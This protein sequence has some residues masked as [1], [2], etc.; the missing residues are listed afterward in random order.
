MLRNLGLSY[1]VLGQG[2]SVCA[3]THTH[4]VRVCVC[5]PLHTLCVCAVHVYVVYVYAVHVQYMVHV[6][7]MVHVYMWSMY[8]GSIYMWSM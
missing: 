4:C 8:I 7:N 6:Y 5:P 1:A 2:A 3:P